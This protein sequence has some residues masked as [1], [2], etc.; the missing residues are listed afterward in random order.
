MAKFWTG[1]NNSDVFSAPTNENWYM[2]GLGGNDDIYG[3]GGNDFLD[4]GAGADYLW[5]GLGN[6]TADYSQSTAAV[7]VDLNSGTGSGGHAQGDTLV[8]IENVTGSSYADLLVGDINANQLAGRNGNDTLKGFG[9]AD[10]L[11]G[12]E[13]VD[14]ASYEGSPSGVVVNLLSGLGSGGHAAGD[15]FYS[16]ENVTGSDHGDTLTGD[17]GSNTL[18]GRGGNDTLKGFG[19]ADYIYGGSGPD[20]LYGM[21]GN[22]QLYGDS[23][24]DVLSGG[25]GNDI[26]TGGGYNTHDTFLFN[27]A[28]NASTN[29]D[30]I[31]DFHSADDVFWLDSD[32]FTTLTP[33][34]SIDDDL[35]WVGSQATTSA[36][37]I[38]YDQ[39]YGMLMY[40]PDGTGSAPAVQFAQLMLGESVQYN[41]FVVVS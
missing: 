31:M 36:H 41:D 32:V 10:T 5:G 26:L 3:A 23:G 2:Y 21:D 25:L 27:T 7:I 22:D 4:G 16:I 6:D 37:R 40:D 33:G 28:L 24:D 14:T 19:G 1:T 12:G 8:Y 39:A 35:F 17:N 13:G 11:W 9:G 34:G 30:T 15:E 29:V 20:G 18:R 38:I